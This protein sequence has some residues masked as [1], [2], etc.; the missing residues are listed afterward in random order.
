[1]TPN[2]LTVVFKR[3]LLSPRARTSLFSSGGRWWIPGWYPRDDRIASMDTNLG[4]LINLLPSKLKRGL[5]P[6]RKSCNGSSKQSAAY[7]STESASMKVCCLTSQIFILPT[8]LERRELSP[9]LIL[10]WW[11]FKI[12]RYCWLS[13]Q[14]QYYSKHCFIPKVDTKHPPQCA[15]ILSLCFNRRLMY[16]IIRGIGFKTSSTKRTVSRHL[17][18]MKLFSDSC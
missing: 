12:H 5:V 2:H 13:W 15:Q 7:S 6:W 1:M 16:W 18:N 3:L 17:T 11:P 4:S 10:L 8:Y 9:S 14:P